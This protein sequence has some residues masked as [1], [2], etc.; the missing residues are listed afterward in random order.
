[1]TAVLTDRVAMVT[2]ARGNLGRAA[3]DAFVAAGSRVAT[4]DRAGGV[5]D[6]PAPVD[7]QR[8]AVFADLLDAA[9]T[10]AAVDAA[11]AHF[12][13]ID[14]L[15]NIAGGFAMGP[16]VHEAP[17]DLWRRMFDLNVMSVVHACRAVVPRMI[18]AAR[19]SIVNVAAASS[20][21]GQA[22]MA[23]YAVAKN[24]VVRVTESMAAELRP[25]GIGVTCVMPTIIDTPENRAAMPDADFSQ[26]T[27]PEAIAEVVL[28]LASDAAMIASGC[29]I[30]LAGRS[31]R[32]RQ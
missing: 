21:R 22:N 17:D 14:V 13:R 25:H 18:A 5:A 27:P 19:G 8:Y 28:F 26:W 11:F 6:V 16:P 12:G 7:A 3:V 29:A 1:M 15:C 23:A 10:R 4:F 20:A 32:N 30:P 31:G 9:S 24:A 2:G